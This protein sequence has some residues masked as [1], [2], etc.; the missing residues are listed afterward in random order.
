MADCCD[1]TCEIDALHK[2]QSTTLK[3]VLAINAPMFAIELVAGLVAGSTALLSDSLD[4]LGDALTHGF[5]LYAVSR[6]PRWAFGCF[7]RG[8]LTCSLGLACLFLL[9]AYRVLRNAF[10]E[11][12]NTTPNIAP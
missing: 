8:G 1:K 7:D 10:A 11:L 5:S 6:G 2:T 3:T 4:N 9:S 12:K